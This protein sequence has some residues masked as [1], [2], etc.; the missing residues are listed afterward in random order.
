MSTPDDHSYSTHRSKRTDD[1]GS[2]APVSDDDTR[3]RSDI[4]MD[5]GASDPGSVHS[6][7]SLQGKIDMLRSSIVYRIPYVH[8]TLPIGPNE[9]IKLFY[10]EQD[11]AHCIDLARPTE[12]RLNRLE[13]ACQPAT[14]GRDQKDVLDE[15]YRKAG[16]M[17]LSHFSTH[18]DPSHAGILKL[19]QDE[20][21]Q[22]GH[23]K[24]TM[25]LYKLNLYGKGSFFKPHKDT[26][27]GDKSFG[28]LVMVFPAPHE[29]GRFVL[30][31][32][33]DEW[34]V[35]A[36]SEIFDSDGA[37]RIVYIAFYGDVM[38][39]VCEVTSGHRVT[40][41][42]NIYT[43]CEDE[44]LP[45]P[46][47]DALAALLADERLL[48]E[49][50]YLAF[51]LRY[52]YPLSD[53]TYMSNHGLKGGDAM[54]VRACEALGVQVSK[55]VLY[56]ADSHDDLERMFAARKDV[57]FMS[58]KR[59]DTSSG[60]AWNDVSEH[61]DYH[62]GI[63][64]RDAGSEPLADHHSVETVWVTPYT[65]RNRVKDTFMAYGNEA[66]TDTVY[67]NFALFIKVDRKKS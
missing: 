4:L 25:E 6:S 7:D 17:D 59:I 1:T 11:N 21:L 51:G 62:S 49:G 3:F 26:P 61:L 18:F 8:G 27:R 29:G 10:G 35:D 14:F 33:G 39:E 58:S 43:D 40:L 28:T 48:P 22:N 63:V 54:I 31:K 20:L 56:G 32:A 66:C 52:D 2:A 38:H 5:D 64:I 67:G 13:E 41:T 44:T 19:V 60:P 45:L 23:D 50:G 9:E 65:Y 55:Y 15:T 57:Y 47:E 34:S 42:W 30:T 36:A 46:R 53:L 24:L 16:K 12:E 37:P